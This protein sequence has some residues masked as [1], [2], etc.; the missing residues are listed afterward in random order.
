[1]HVF[2]CVSTV[3]VIEDPLSVLVLLLGGVALEYSHLLHALV[4]RVLLI[5]AVLEVG[6]LRE[7]E[8]LNDLLVLAH[9]RQNRVRRE[10]SLHLIVDLINKCIVLKFLLMDKAIGNG[11][12]EQ[13]RISELL[14]QLRGQRCPHG[15]T[16]EKEGANN[17]R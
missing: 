5:V 4:V 17:G 9:C 11:G 1:M 16:H 10:L 6:E 3:E 13:G 7:S 8:V 12:T 2:E 14:V 15:E